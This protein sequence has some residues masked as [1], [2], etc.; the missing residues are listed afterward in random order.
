MHFFMCYICM[1]ISNGCTYTF[2]LWKCISVNLKRIER[3]EVILQDENFHQLILQITYFLFIKLVVKYF[4]RIMI[5][6]LRL[7][8][9]LYRL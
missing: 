3:I 9:P 2:H 4:R 7:L 8:D 6:K 5:G 1:C